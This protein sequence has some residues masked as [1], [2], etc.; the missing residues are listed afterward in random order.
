[1][2]ELVGLLDRLAEADWRHF[3]QIYEVLDA[4]TASPRP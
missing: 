4:A 2:E 3:R 1:M